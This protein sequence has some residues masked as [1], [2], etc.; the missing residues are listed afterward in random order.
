MAHALMLAITLATAPIPRLFAQGSPNAPAVTGAVRYESVPGASSCTVAGTSTLHDWEMKTTLISGSME[1]DAD[2]P[3]SALAT[4]GAA[5]PVV[6]I[7]VPLR[8]LKS[9]KAAMDN[10]MQDHMEVTKNP[11]VEYRVL[12]LK[13]KS[14][15][16]TKGA[17]QFDAVGTLSIYG[18]TLT[19]T[20]P[21]SIEKKD[22]KLTVAGSTPIKM[23]DYG[24]PKLTAFGLTVGDDLSITFN[25]VS[26]PKV[27]AP[28]Q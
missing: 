6:R 22:G 11:N 3:E 21:V 23:S 20:M 2:F 7:R 4:P 25:W 5:K 8:T 10:K 14:P 13:P 24:I 26:A 27:K 9:D 19:N 12:E 17:I 15:T 16:G 1:A 28:T 18:K